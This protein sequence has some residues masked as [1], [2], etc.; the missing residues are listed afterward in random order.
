MFFFIERIFQSRKEIIVC[1]AAAF[2][3]FFNKAKNWLYSSRCTNFLQR[4]NGAYFEQKPS[5][6]LLTFFFFQRKEEAQTKERVNKARRKN[7][8]QNERGRA[9]HRSDDT[10]PRY[11]DVPHCCT[12][13]GTFRAPSNPRYTRNSS[14]PDIVPAFVSFLSILFFP[15]LNNVA[16]SN[17]K[18]QTSKV[19]GFFYKKYTV[20]L[21]H[22]LKRSVIS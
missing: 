4:G 1:F 22:Y 14:R 2:S 21:K 8:P 11:N 18:I 15:K 20:L 9:P 6:V 5:C 17:P 13:E 16:F 19:L 12:N 10:W 7:A 3:S